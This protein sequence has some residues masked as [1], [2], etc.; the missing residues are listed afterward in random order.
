MIKKSLGSLVLVGA[1]L[2]GSNASAQEAG[3]FDQL[4]ELRQLAKQEAKFCNQKALEKAARRADANA[5][6][7]EDFFEIVQKCIDIKFELGDGY[8]A[9]LG[10][11]DDS[12]DDF[13]DESFS[14][15]GIKRPTVKT[16]KNG[17]T[18]M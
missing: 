13:D 5:D 14:A 12:G 6:F 8:Q 18:T 15:A 7:E 9:I 3:Y 11:G 17:G 10:D 2:V 1:M 16:D 4:K